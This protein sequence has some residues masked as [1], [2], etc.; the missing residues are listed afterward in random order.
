ML[1]GL[2]AMV[3]PKPNSLVTV[4]MLCNAV[5]LNKDAKYFKRGLENRLRFDEHVAIDDGITVGESITCRDGDDAIL[6]ATCDDGSVTARLHPCGTEV[7]YVSITLGLVRRQISV[8]DGITCRGRDDV[9]LMER[10][11]D[12][13]VKVKLLPWGTLVSY[14]SIEKICIRQCE[15]PVDEYH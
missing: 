9:V 15:P 2:C 6:V 13:S 5:G 11:D 10:G 8:G 1:T 14:A 7:D 12:G 4:N 3:A